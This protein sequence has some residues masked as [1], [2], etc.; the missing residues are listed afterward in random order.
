M[1]HDRPGSRA[2]H[3]RCR[4]IAFDADKSEP[5][6]FQPCMCGHSTEEHESSF[7]RPCKALE[8]QDAT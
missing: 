1:K 2:E 8:I 7:M 3:E 6:D 4:C 5:G